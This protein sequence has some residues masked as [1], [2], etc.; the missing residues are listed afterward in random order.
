MKKILIN[1]GKK[2]GWAKYFGENL[3]KYINTANKLL[4]KILNNIE[5]LK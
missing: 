3:I 5:I 4:Y 2:K 1:L